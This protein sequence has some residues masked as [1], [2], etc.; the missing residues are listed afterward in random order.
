MADF[1]L[2][3][4]QQHSPQPQQSLQQQPHAPQPRRPSPSSSF[5]PPPSSPPPHSHSSPNRPPSASSR[6][7]QLLRDALRRGST[8]AASPRRGA[9]GSDAGGRTHARAASIGGVPGAA[10]LLQAYAGGGGVYGGDAEFSHAPWQHHDGA[11]ARL[12]GRVSSSPSSP[13]PYSGRRKG[14]GVVERDPEHEALRAR[15]ERV[16]AMSDSAGGGAA[17]SRRSSALTDARTSMSSSSGGGAS[18]RTSLSA[19]ASPLPAHAASGIERPRTPLRSV[20]ETTGPRSPTS[21][22]GTPRTPTPPTPRTPR[23]DSSAESGEERGGT[24]QSARRIGRSDVEVNIRTENG[25]ADADVDAKE[26]EKAGRGRWGG[27][28]HFV[29]FCLGGSVRSLV[30]VLVLVLSRLARSLAF[31][32]P[33]GALHPARRFLLSFLIAP[34]GSVGPAQAQMEQTVRRL[35]WLAGVLA[36]AGVRV[37]VWVSAHLLHMGYS[38]LWAIPLLGLALRLNFFLSRLRFCA[39]FYDSDSVL[40]FYRRLIVVPADMPTGTET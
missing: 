29:L 24:P 21:R 4:P 5:L 1:C 37:R 2:F 19:S 34:S 15:L 30:L 6:S 25:D 36:L 16:L 40:L 12:E 26:R 8:A 23:R 10:H 11:L 13:A 3:Q 27:E 28:F 32:F 9:A 31:S 35:A 7:E 39:R 14:A 17:G 18:A 33:S 38:S 20:G 22:P